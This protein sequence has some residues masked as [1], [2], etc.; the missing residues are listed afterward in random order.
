MPPIQRV[1]AYELHLNLVLPLLA[2]GGLRARSRHP[3]GVQATLADGSVRFVNDS[4]AVPI[5]NAAGT[6]HGEEAIPGDSL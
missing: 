6:I 3:G 1:L 2:F 5:W 4:I